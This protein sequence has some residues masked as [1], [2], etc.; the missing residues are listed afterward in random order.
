MLRLSFGQQRENRMGILGV[1]CCSPTWRC[2]L[3]A[4]PKPAL[5]AAAALRHTTTISGSTS[6]PLVAVVNV[7]STA[8]LDVTKVRHDAIAVLSARTAASLMGASSHPKSAFGINLLL[9][10]FSF[11]SYGALKKLSLSVLSVAPFSL[12]VSVVPYLTFS[13]TLKCA[14]RSL[15]LFI[16]GIYFRSLRHL[17]ALSHS[18]ALFWEEKV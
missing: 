3:S 15:Q 13:G 4:T 10:I 14:P 9:I 7:K 11:F 17:C 5:L 8:L 12:S 6:F 1:Y 18:L 16:T 2:R